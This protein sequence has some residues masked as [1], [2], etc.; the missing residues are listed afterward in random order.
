[1]DMKGTHMQENKKWYRL[2]NAAKIYPAVRSLKWASIFRMTAILKE[3]IDP[4]L[5][6]QALD[7]TVQRFPGL[8]LRMKKGLFWFYFVQNEERLLLRKDVS[9]PCMPM[10]RTE[11]GGHLLR[12]RYY[13][14]KIAVEVFHS[15]TDGTGCLSFLKTL[16]AQY[17]RLKGVEI[18]YEGGILDCT[19]QPDAEEMEDGFL[20]YATKGPAKTRRET[21]AYRIS[22]VQEHEMDIR[23]I[24][25]VLPVQSLREQAA[26]R[27]VSITELLVGVLAYS[28]YQIQQR[29]RR[30]RK[31][32]VKISMPINLRR[33]F[34]TKTLRNFSSFINP[35]IEPKY[36]IYTLEETIQLVHHYV[37]Y[38][39][40]EKSMRAWINKNVRDERNYLIRAVPLF[41]KNIVLGIAYKMTGESR[42]SSVLTNLGP[43]TVPDTMRPYVERFEF[44]LGLSMQIKVHSAALSY[45][46]D[47]IITFS[48]S[49]EEPK[50][51]HEFFTTLIKMGVSVQVSSNNEYNES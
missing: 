19:Q 41:L 38:H 17:L 9:N 23:I 36:G 42:F 10:S 35:G 2:D 16:T 20:R 26:A 22:G 13:N 28:I 3:R 39:V 37:R 46:E 7:M 29:E 8:T 27:K 44:M 45:G 49:I 21:K 1:M 40:N 24:T 43:V 5:L 15:L 47:M 30:R 12:V 14:C 4:V 11:N 33:F 18:P 50:V 6:Q 51:E 25:G 32:P 31:D 48:R 34:P